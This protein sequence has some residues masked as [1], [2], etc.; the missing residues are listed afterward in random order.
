VYPVGGVKAILHVI[1]DDI[2]LDKFERLK[3]EIEKITR[4]AIKD[5][6]LF[7]DN[8]VEFS[9]VLCNQSYFSFLKRVLL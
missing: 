9:E 7:N 6:I 5:Q 3:R 2:Y 1:V 4:I 8:H